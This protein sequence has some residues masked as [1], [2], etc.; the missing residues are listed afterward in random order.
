HASGRCPAI[1]T[2][3]SGPGSQEVLDRWKVDWTQFA[4]LKG[5]VVL[6][7]DTRGT[8]GKGRAWETVTYRNLGHYESIDL[9]GAARWLAG[10]SYVD[11]QRIGIPGWSYGGYETLMA[12][13]ATDGGECPFACAVAIAP[14]T[15]WRYYD[16]VYSERYMLT[17][18]EN[19]Q[20]YEESSPMSHVE[21]MDIPLL[22][23]HGTADD[24][25]HLMNT[26]QYVSVIQSTGRF[27]DMFLYPNMNHSINGC[28]ARLNVYSRM[29]DYF[30][31]N[32]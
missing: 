21:Q 16:S 3:Y 4:A 17:P 5:Y 30:D 9:R 6:C 24:N 14:V 8:G 15:S 25:V 27:C 10:Q 23:M 1:I 19:A 28:G 29:L 32:M 31:K 11:P 18:G 22:L 7:V 26:L 2:H 20:G 12:I 13:S